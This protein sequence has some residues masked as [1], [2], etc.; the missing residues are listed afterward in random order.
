LHW[1]DH[2]IAFSPGLQFT[3]RRDTVSPIQL[4]Q[5]LFRQFLYVYSSPFWNWLSFSGD[6]LHES[7]PFAE[8]NLHSKDNSAS[9]N[10]I[11]GR[12]WGKTALITG[13]QARDIQFHP[14]VSEYYT[15]S[16]YAGLRRKFGERA[17]VSIFG[18]YLRSWR[19]QDTSFAIAQAIRPAFRMNY[20]FSKHWAVQGS[21]VWSRGEG[22]HAYDNVNDQFLVTYIRPVERSLR[23]GGEDVPVRYPMSFSFG[24]QQQTFYDFQGTNRNTLLPVIRLTIF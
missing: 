7:G 18:E 12:P 6:V 20:T 22:F 19:V 3:L 9:L 14:V 11:V 8:Q 2:A 4:N 10:F 15:T 17:E 5:D 13:Y 16:S 21:G 24:M 23:D 1:G